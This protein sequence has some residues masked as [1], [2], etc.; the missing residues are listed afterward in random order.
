MF[1]ILCYV[2][3]YVSWLFLYW[4]RFQIATCKGLPIWKLSFEDFHLESAMLL[5]GCNRNF[6]DIDVCTEIQWLSCTYRTAPTE[7]YRPIPNSVGKHRTSSDCEHIH[8]WRLQWLKFNHWDPIIGLQSPD[9]STC[10]NMFERSTCI[11]HLNLAPCKLGWS[12]FCGR[13]TVRYQT[14]IECCVSQHR[15]EPNFWIGNREDALQ[16]TES[17]HSRAGTL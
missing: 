5:S 9:T 12:S 4:T 3:F 8:D 1:N 2:D 17:L 10:S 15:G 11:K 14:E 13:K 6:P 7:L 16:I